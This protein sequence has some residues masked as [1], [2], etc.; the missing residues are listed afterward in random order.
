[1][2]LNA[3]K[4]VIATGPSRN[5]NNYLRNQGVESSHYVGFDQIEK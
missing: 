5:R 1:L 3:E 2:P 4:R